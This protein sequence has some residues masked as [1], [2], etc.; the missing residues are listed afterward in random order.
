MAT[1]SDARELRHTP[2]E[3][4]Q[5]LLPCL[6]CQAGPC[7]A[8]LLLCVQKLCDLGYSSMD[9]ITTLFRV[10]RNF[11]DLAEFLKLEF[12]RVRAPARLLTTARVLARDGQVSLAAQR[13]WSRIHHELSRKVTV[14][15]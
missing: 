8:G 13:G 2:D 15:S 9:I 3:P 11:P 4:R 7:R 1:L 14:Y 10:V 12:I 6:L 5:Q